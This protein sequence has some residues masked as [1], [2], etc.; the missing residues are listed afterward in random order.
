MVSGVREDGSWN[1]RRVGGFRGE[2]PAGAKELASA[3][4]IA[5]AEDIAGTV[6]IA[7]GGDQHLEDYY[8]ITVM[9][10]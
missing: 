9:R 4:E 8:I 6:A 2:S 10:D 1:S 5:G 3:E 7:S